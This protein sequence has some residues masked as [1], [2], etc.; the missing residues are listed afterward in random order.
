MKSRVP[1]VALVALVVAIAIILRRI[2]GVDVFGVMI[3][4]TII[5]MAIQNIIGTPTWAKPGVALALKPLLRAGIVLLGFKMVMSEIAEVGLGGFLI[6]AATL[7]STY[8][9]TKWFGRILNANVRTAELIAVGTSICGASAIIAVNSVIRGKDEE[10][11]YSVACITIFG[12]V[13]MFLFPLVGTVLGM[14][15]PAFGLWSGSAIHEVAQVIGS[16]FQFSEDAGQVA[17][18]SKL[19]RVVLLAP[20]VVA[21]SFAARRNPANVDALAVPTKFP[22]PWFVVGFLVVVILNSVYS[23]PDSVRSGLGQVSAFFL[24]MALGAM[25][26]ETDFKKLRALGLKPFFVAAAAWLFVSLFSLTFVF[27]VRVAQ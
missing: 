8:F 2:P 4:S 24:A 7:V 21:I 20:M 23:V 26:L 25:G 18:V 17:T 5:G 15:D 6:I 11:A 19:S 1:G 22:V 27:L 10:V 14:N 12:T 16:G 9:V 3:L 13:S